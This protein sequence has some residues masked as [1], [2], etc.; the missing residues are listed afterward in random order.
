MAAEPGRMKGF[1]ITFAV[2][3]VVGL[4]A[5]AWVLS[6]PSTVEIPVNVT[7]QPGDTAG[8]QG[9][10]LGSP[11]APVEITEFADY[12]CPFCQTFATMQMPTI[13]DRLIKTGRLRFRYRDFPL[14]MHPHS[15]LAAHAAACADDQHKYWPMHDRLYQGQGDWSESDDATAIFRGY[16]KALGLDVAAYDACMTSARYAGRIQ[17]SYD[18]GV[19]YGVPSTP[20]MMIGDKLYSGRLDSDAILHLVDSLAPVG[21]AADSASHSR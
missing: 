14:P 16:A 8:F 21:A 13:E 3:A 4:G 6:R 19:R 17:A 2:V 12:Q 18:L 15:R 7:V 5:I 10:V 1:Y 9:Y 20:T 11:D